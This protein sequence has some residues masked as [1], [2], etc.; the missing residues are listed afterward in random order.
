MRQSARRIKR[1]VT[2]LL[3]TFSIAAVWLLFLPWIATQP[4]TAERLRFLEERGID[5]SAMY[6]TELDAMDR[7][8]DRLERP[9]P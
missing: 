9:R 1:R 7:I 8:L 4:S 5:P 3:V 2:L 6:Y